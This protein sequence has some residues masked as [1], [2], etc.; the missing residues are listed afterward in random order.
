MTHSQVT[1]AHQAGGRLYV[2]NPIELNPVV[3]SKDGKYV[4]R[5]N[6]WNPFDNAQ[7]WAGILKRFSDQDASIS[8]SWRGKDDCVCNI[9][10]MV[11]Y[12]GKGANIYVPVIADGQAPTP[13]EAVVNACIN[14]IGAR[15][16][17]QDRRAAMYA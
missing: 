4:M 3:Q 9:Y 12:E 2:G 11:M 10:L 14:F 5:Y 15:K 6:P 7:D 16:A 13:G 8:L 17:E 1:M